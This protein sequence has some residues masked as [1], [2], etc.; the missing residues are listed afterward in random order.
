MEMSEEVFKQLYSVREAARYLGISQWAV[1][2][3]NWSSKLPCVRQG[4]R[5]L[6][7]IYDMD[8]F[9][10]N[11]KREG[12]HGDDLPTQEARSDDRDFGRTGPILDEILR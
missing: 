7:D 1:R 10:E 11:N 3:L 9:I 8:R 12:H 2:H 6:F 5:V 4:R